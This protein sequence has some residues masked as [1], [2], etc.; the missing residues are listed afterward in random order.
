MGNPIDNLGGYGKITKILKLFGG[1]IALLSGTVMAAGAVI[2][3]G[4]EK[5]TPYVKEKIQKRKDKA[6]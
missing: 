2:Y 6:K 5:I 1:S 3:A 4:A